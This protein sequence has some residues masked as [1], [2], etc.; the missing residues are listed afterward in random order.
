M[1]VWRI[2]DSHRAV[3]E[4]SIRLA[5]FN[6]AERLKANRNKVD[7][8]KRGMVREMA[9]YLVQRRNR[10]SVLAGRLGNLSPLSVLK[11][12]YALARKK[13]DLMVLRSSSEVGVGDKINLVLGEGELDVVVDE[14]I[15]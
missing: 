3:D 5:G 1:V 10:L 11:R 12:G 2:S 6:P 14:V 8:L 15:K 7:G 9:G 4:A 13:T